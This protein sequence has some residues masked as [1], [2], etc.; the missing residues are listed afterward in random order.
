MYKHILIPTDGSELAEHAVTH[1]LSL[2]KSVGAIVMVMIVEEP[3]NWP[4]IVWPVDPG[5][6]Q[7]LAEY[8][9]QIK[10]LA[11]SALN[12]A[13]DAAKQA[14][15]SCETVQLGDAQPLSSQRCNGHGSG[16]RSYRYGIAWPQRPV[17][18]FARQCDKQGA[19]A[20]ENPRT[21]LSVNVCRPLDG[22]K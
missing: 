1:G 13:A 16:L 21:G 2:A 7:P 3:F 11:A 15:V 19:G 8:G 9:E 4:P 22:T 6:L 20:R 18:G 17:R 5:A 14:G 12:R 10:K